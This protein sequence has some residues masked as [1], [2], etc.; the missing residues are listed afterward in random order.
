ML[1]QHSSSIHILKFASRTIGYCVNI[2]NTHL[3]LEGINNE[4]QG[5]R[6]DTFNAFLHHMVP[7]LILHTLQHVAIKLPDNV[8]LKQR[9]YF[10]N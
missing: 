9:I 7:I 3:S 6:L 1:C 10:F 8:V 4:L 5:L 2:T